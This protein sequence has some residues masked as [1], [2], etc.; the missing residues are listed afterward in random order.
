MSSW[1]SKWDTGTKLKV[2]LTDGSEVEL[3]IYGTILYDTDGDL[4]GELSVSLDDLFPDSE[5]PDGRTYH[6]QLASRGKSLRWSDRQQVYLPLG[7]D[8]VRDLDD[9]E[10]W[11]W[12]NI[13]FD[14]SRVY[15]WK[16]VVNRVYPTREAPDPVEHRK[17]RASRRAAYQHGQFAGFESMTPAAA[18]SKLLE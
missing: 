2:R 18:V 1:D 9:S 8:S 15:P 3:P 11:D 16:W 5:T 12:L 14:N 6:V 4:A 17:D 10:V 7:V 13:K